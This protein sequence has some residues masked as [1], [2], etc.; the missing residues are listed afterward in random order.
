MNTDT[1]N[2]QAN[3][4]KAVPT[5][6][7]VLGV[8]GILLLVGLFIWG[9]LWLASH[10]GPQLEAIRDIVII[11]LALES[12]IFGVAFILLLIMVIRLINMIEFEV[13]P[14]LQKTN[15]TVGTIRGTTQFVS[16]NVV[17][18]VTKASSYM[19]GI[20]RGLTVLLG[21]PRRNLHD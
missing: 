3:R 8:V 12:C 4:K 20:R 16:Q 17:K 13:K 7:V 19:A 6:Y 9:I 1:T 11:A 14:I 2:Y 21:N 18:P 10:S 5:L 15:E